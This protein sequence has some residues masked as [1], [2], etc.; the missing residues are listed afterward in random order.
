MATMPRVIRVLSS[1]VATF[2][3][4][5]SSY[6]RWYQSIGTIAGWARVP[7]N[8][9][10]AL[11]Y[12]PTFYCCCYDSLYTVT[13]RSGSPLRTPTQRRVLRPPGQTCSIRWRILSSYSK[14]AHT[15][16]PCKGD[17]STVA[18]VLTSVAHRLSATVWMSV[19]CQRVYMYLHAC[20]HLQYGLANHGLIFSLVLVYFTLIS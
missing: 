6:R 3:L 11:R 17:C 4:T 1:Y 9:A 19:G 18:M 5:A 14:R 15:C 20:G 16:A 7:T 12:Q 8:S 2:R 10:T 13:Q